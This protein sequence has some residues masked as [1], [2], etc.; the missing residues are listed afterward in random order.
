MYFTIS[1]ARLIFDGRRSDAWKD[2]RMDGLMDEGMD[3]LTDGR[4][5]G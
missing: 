1:I 4:M 5:N 2:V 3:E